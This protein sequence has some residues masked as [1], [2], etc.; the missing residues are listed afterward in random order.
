GARPPGGDGAGADPQRPREP[1]PVRGRDR[2]SVAGARGAAR[3]RRESGDRALRA[4]ERTRGALRGVGYAARPPP[5][6]D[7]AQLSQRAV[8]DL[9]RL[10]GRDRAGSR[11]APDAHGA[12]RSAL[13]RA[14]RAR[15][16]AL[17][18]GFALLRRTGVAQL[19]RGRAS[20]LSKRPKASEDPGWAKPSEVE[21]ADSKRWWW[22]ARALR[23]WSRRRGAP[24][25]PT[26][27][28]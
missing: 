10:D 7:D 6:V 16:A 2:R 17:H 21:K 24:R 11:R 13:R 15:A 3:A 4:A 9:A 18:R 27:R 5:Q 28:P 8:G 12:R 19:S 23:R 22:W 25:T 14:Q 20:D 26:S 1:P